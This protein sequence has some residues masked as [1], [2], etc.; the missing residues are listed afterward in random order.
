MLNAIIR[1]SLK[2]RFLV[3]VLAVASMVYGGILLQN[4]PVDVFPNLNRPTV[5]IITESHG[6]APE[7]VETLVTLP[8]ESSMSGV[9]GVMRVRSSSGIGISIIYI[10]FDWGTDIYRNRQLVA[11]K[12][13]LVSGRLPEDI[14]PV[15]GPITSIMGEIQFIGL[16]TE[17]NQL[18][19][20]MQMR[21]LADW[22]VRPK[23]M[24]IPG[25]SQ[26][27]VMG[28]Q[29]KQFQ[30]LVS[31][32]KLQSKGISLEDLKHSLSEI[33]ENTTG[34]FVDIDGK[35]F[36]IRPLGRV[37]DV[38]QIENSVVGL[39][40]GRPVLVKDIAEVRIGPKIKRGE[41]SVNGQHSVVMTIQKQPSAN[42][43][44]LTK[45]IEESLE[46]IRKALPKGIRLEADLFKQA[47]FIKA[48]IS[49]V[50][51][52]LRDGAIMVAIILFLFLLNWRTTGITLVAI[53]LSLLVTAIVFHWMGLGINTMTLGGLAVAIGELV[54]DAIVDVENVFRR[55]KENRT[56]KNPLHPLKVV[57]EA[58][59][60]VRNSIVISTI[61]VV[62]V[63]IPL[64]ALGGIEGR[65]FAPLGV[66]Y[67][68]SLLASLVVS[69]TLTPVLCYYLLPNA[70][71]MDREQDGRLVSL[72]KSID[73]T[74]ILKV[75]DRPYL[76]LGGGLVLLVSSL[77]LLFFM[78]SNFLPP[79]NEG[80]ATIGVA[81]PP[82]I[83]LKDS[84]DLGQ[85][86]EE[87]IL[88]V[89]EVKSTVRRTGRA[90]MDEHAEG[91]HWSEIDV[92]F[93]HETGRGR[94]VVLQEIREKIEDTGDVY[95]NIGQ[96]ISHRLDHLL[97]GVRAQIAVKIFGP[98]LEELRRLGYEVEQA[99]RGIKGI[100]DLQLEPLV[101][102][103]QLKILMDRE[104][105]ARWGVRPGTVAE[106]LEMAL[107]GES[108][109]SV[110]E[111][112]R[113]FD[114]FMRL[115]DSSRATPENIENVLIK[116]M[117]TGKLVRVRDVAYVYKGSGP[118]MINRENVQRRII[119]QA[120]SQGRDLSGLIKEIQA[121]IAEKVKFPEGYFVT[122]GGQFES[123]QQA[124]KMLVILGGL[125]LLGIFI[126]LYL[127][128]RSTMLAAQVMVNV[129]LALI[130]GVI[131]IYLTERE[132][133][134]ATLI[135]FITLCGIAS[136]NGILMINHYIHLMVEEGEKFTKE[137]VIRG[138]LERLVPVLMTAFSAALALVPLLLSKGEPGKEILYPVAIVIV[139]GLF[140]ST[141][142]DVIVTPVVFYNFGRKPAERLFKFKRA[143]AQKEG[144]I[145]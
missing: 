72:L 23:L 73:R 91:V 126:I 26:V 74:V 117:P 2:N 27:V 136:R 35:E 8:I 16:V 88:S 144:D 43:L 131:G 41:A 47:N 124:S 33:S 79:F 135:A 9:P 112:Q 11:E 29:V 52:A 138:S 106:E 86:I 42:T 104:E 63:F 69:L 76:V 103:P 64:F 57:F 1:L 66:A 89:P 6:L 127:N 116:T 68:V 62:L 20:P 99:M 101:L 5:T 40:F 22:V 107:N 32:E 19:D 121:T 45:R 82:G 70:K 56:L 17:E 59:S 111:N 51:E 85:R 113:I 10:E 38:E 115:N 31:S 84:D 92:D 139:S 80:T 49:N 119:V 60:E 120:N 90:E 95:V 93:H 15:L 48:S 30:I 36:L 28:G 55:L 14:T 87:A 39:Q 96:P 78:G 44:D 129:P 108:V 98:D 132:L 54:D 102:V 105:S 118:N 145:L 34:G 140:T 50:E 143:E 81:A 65:L 133:S 58:S 94:R 100:V 83:A 46:G 142:L 77:S 3:L 21:T 128:F 130:G 37:E 134:V 71:V 97:S 4:L 61:I 109:G 25:I 123:Q 12:L 24:T 125:S 141:L 53:P 75:I 114:I 18:V 13:Q 122:Y 137:M 110:I 7:E 67:I